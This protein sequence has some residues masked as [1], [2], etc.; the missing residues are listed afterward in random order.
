MIVRED[1]P[2]AHQLVQSAHAAHEAGIRYGN[3]DDISSLVVCSVADEAEL[4]RAAADCLSRGIGHFLFFEED[5][6]GQATAFATEPI[7]GATRKAFKKFPL[8]SPAR[9]ESVK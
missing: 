3:P 2:P 8:W 5:L 7:T 1:L 6:G 4:R 9:E